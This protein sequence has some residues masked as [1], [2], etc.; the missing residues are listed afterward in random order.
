MDGIVKLPI[1]F[2]C[3]HDA[4]L[5]RLAAKITTDELDGISD[6]RDK[7]VGRVYMK[8]LEVFLEVRDLRTWDCPPTR[9]PWSP[10]IAVQCGPGQQMAVITSDC[11]PVRSRRFR[12]RSA[13]TAGGSSPQSST[14]G[15][16]ALL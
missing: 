15:W 12:S 10:R 2:G 11:V 14:I 3:I 1:D 16:S 13:S 7:L 5:G 4:L 9:R 6:A 8:K